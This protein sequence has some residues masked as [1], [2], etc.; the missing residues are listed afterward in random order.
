LEDTLKN[1]WMGWMFKKLDEAKKKYQNREKRKLKRR[2]LKKHQADIERRLAWI[3]YFYK[4]LDEGNK[5]AKTMVCNKFNI[6]YKT[7][8][9][10]LKRYEENKRSPWALIDLPKR[11]K[12]IKFKVP[13]WA[14]VLI[15]LAR[16]IRG[17][18][19]EALAA[20][21]RHRGIFNISHQ[22]VHNIFVRYG[23]H[24]IKRLKKKPVM[25]YERGKPNELWHIDI[26]GPFWI[27]G[28]GKIY[29]IG[30]IDDYSR[31]IVACELKMDQEMETVIAELRA[32]IAKYGEPLEIINDNGLQFVS[33]QEG[34]LNGFQK[35]LNELGIKQIRCRV[36]TPETNGKI[37]RFWKTLESECLSWYYFTSL[38]GV[39]VKVKEFV[40]N[41]NHHRL[42]KALG[43]RPPVERY[44]GKRVGNKGFKNFWGLEHLDLVYKRLK[45][46]GEFSLEDEEFNK[47]SEVV[48]A[49]RQAA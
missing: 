27:K 38:E 46:A 41:Y 14:E 8:N 18:G 40:N 34:S 30:I 32:A 43:W 21:F 23:L 25:R 19:A 24:H 49:Y 9:F 33:L 48:L 39:L 29:T 10:W 42:S 26:K 5:A 7:L 28:V 11:P 13:F 37:E 47:V 17:I 31:Y 4:L 44:F 2:L 16:I 6:D 1:K 36:H 3:N 12:N 22:G 15:V 45:G 20:E 35:L